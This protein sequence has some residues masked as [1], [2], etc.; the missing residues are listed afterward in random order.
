MR[1]IKSSEGAITIR[2]VAELSGVSASTVSR[3]LNNSLAVAN[4]KRAAVLDA[5]EKLG[6]RPNVI[7]QELARGRSQAIGV[8]IQGIANPFFSR[9]LRGI[10]HGLRASGYY[11]L[12][13]SGEQ[14][15]DEARSL[16][17][18]LAHRVDA[19]VLIG[20]HLPDAE[21]V[22]LAERVP[23]VAIG[24][25][26]RG[27]EPRCVRVAN[28]DGGYKATRHLLNLGHK[29]IAHILGLPY[30]ADAIARREG[31]ERALLSASLSLDPALVVEGDFEEQ[32][33]F[34]AVEKLLAARTPFTAIF[35]GN[36]QMAYGAGLALLRHGL[37]VPDDVSLVGFD[38]QPNAAYTWP[39]LTTIR[40]PTTEMGLATVKALLDQL[41]GRGFVL[42]TFSTDLVLRDSTGPPPKR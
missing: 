41:R 2:H 18:L 39:P 9:V 7:A 8:L 28:R 22:R 33:G 23:L 35:A 1:T 42:P 21:L 31:Y 38:D 26:I 24:R 40:Q 3:V 32:S 14:P 34:G 29:R 25:T 27:L 36:D 20:G 37:R 19:L 30:H 6:Y 4:V 10:E 12:F 15:E 11:P 5:V 16:E 13:A 17:L